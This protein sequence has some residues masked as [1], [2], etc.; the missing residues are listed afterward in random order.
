MQRHRLPFFL[1]VFCELHHRGILVLLNE[2]TGL[3]FGLVEHIPGAQYML[4]E[5]NW[6]TLSMCCC[7]KS[8]IPCWVVV[9]K[10]FSIVTN[11][12]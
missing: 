7:I 3:Q 4:G 1:V 11:V 2:S 6:Y 12:V 8:N 10:M 5:K 9:M